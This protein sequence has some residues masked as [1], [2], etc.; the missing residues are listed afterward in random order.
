M[1]CIDCNYI[2]IMNRKAFQL[3]KCFFGMT[4]F[5]QRNMDTID[6]ILNSIDSRLKPLVKDFISDYTVDNP[7]LTFNLKKRYIRSAGRE[8][9]AITGI[10]IEHSDKGSKPVLTGTLE[11]YGPENYSVTGIAALVDSY[12]QAEQDL[13]NRLRNELFHK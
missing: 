1:I 10:L 11:F 3:N 4:V 2:A 9:Y 5:N 8:G 12:K 13:K 6:P 7:N